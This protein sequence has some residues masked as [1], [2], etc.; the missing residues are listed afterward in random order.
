MDEFSGRGHL[1]WKKN[2]FSIQPHTVYQKLMPH[3][4]VILNDTKKQEENITNLL[5]GEHATQQMK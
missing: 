1:H 5:Q 2:K 4:R 3:E